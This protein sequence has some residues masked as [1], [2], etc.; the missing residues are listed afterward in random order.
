M[1]RIFVFLTTNSTLLVEI[2]QKEDKHE[3]N[4]YQRAETAMLNS[5][6]TLGC[7]WNKSLEGWKLLTK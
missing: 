6:V 1:P 5:K 7:K 2:D 4:A 3:S